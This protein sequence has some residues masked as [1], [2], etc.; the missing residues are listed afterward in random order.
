MTKKIR[1]TQI[2]NIDRVEDVPLGYLGNGII[3]RNLHIS[4]QSKP[5]YYFQ[6]Y[7]IHAF[8]IVNQYNLSY[9]VT[10]SSFLTQ[11]KFRK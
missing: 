6:L 9:N 2:D 4:K 10:I 8:K 3:G 1:D 11:G 7:W 5:D